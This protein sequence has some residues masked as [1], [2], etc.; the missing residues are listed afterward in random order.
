MDDVDD[1]EQKPVTQISLT[2]DMVF[3]ENLPPR[4]P[5]RPRSGISK[6][7]NNYSPDYDPDTIDLFEDV[8]GLTPN[9]NEA[10]TDEL[11]HNADDVIDNLV[12][13]YTTEIGKRLREEL[14]THL[15]SILE[16]LDHS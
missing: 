15:T 8:A 10:V 5:P 12:D 16:D 13:E 3:D 4:P 1:D 9:I 14:A 11:R 6:P 2:N 7:R